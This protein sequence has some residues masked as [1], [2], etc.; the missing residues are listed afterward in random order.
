MPRGRDDT[1]S[2]PRKA[3]VLTR[4]KPVQTLTYSCHTLGEHQSVPHVGTCQCVRVSHV[5]GTQPAQHTVVFMQP[6]T[7]DCTA[8]TTYALLI[9]WTLS[10]IISRHHAFNQH[11]CW[12][13]LENSFFTQRRRT[14]PRV[15]HIHHTRYSQ[16]LHYQL[17]IKWSKN[18]AACPYIHIHHGHD[19]SI[20]EVL[21][22]VSCHSS[23]NAAA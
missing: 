5:S 15:K 23:T 13:S 3:N 11:D 17:R 4:R 8:C 14:P 9:N 12:L 1:V 18:H 10:L 7:F 22:P 6:P 2:H 21:S 20:P 19:Y 16:S